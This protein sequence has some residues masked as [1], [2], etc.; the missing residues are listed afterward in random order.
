[1]SS[2]D[3]IVLSFSALEYD[4]EDRDEEDLCSRDCEPL[5]KVGEWLE[6]HHGQTLV[7]LAGT[8]LGSNAALFGFCFNYLEIDEL[9]QYIQGLKWRVLEAVRLLHWGD[10]D[11]RFTCIE[12]PLKESNDD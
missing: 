1:M 6:Q 7:D 10:E 9:C 3:S 4:D 8:A 5:W 11:D 2:Y 12:F